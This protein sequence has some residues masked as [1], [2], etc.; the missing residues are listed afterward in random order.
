V[1]HLKSQVGI[2]YLDNISTG[3]IAYVIALVKNGKEIWDQY[4]HLSAA[5]V[6]AMT[7]KKP[8]LKPKFTRGKGQKR[9][10]CESLE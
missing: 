1:R 10:R 2:C 3:D 9:M 8:K 4:L 5:G 6:A 7:Y